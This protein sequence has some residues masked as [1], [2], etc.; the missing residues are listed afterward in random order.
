MDKILNSIVFA[1]PVNTES[2]PT[3]DYNVSSVNDNFVECL[4]LVC[5]IGLAN[6]KVS[7]VLR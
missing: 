7:G 1:G 3:R 6:W 4:S 2:V 5:D